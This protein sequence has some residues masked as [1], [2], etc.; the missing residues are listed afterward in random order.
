MQE[1]INL[2][3]PAIRAN[4]YPSYARMRLEGPV[5]QV[6]PGGY[7]AVSRAADIELVLKNPQ[8]FSSSGFGP[9]LQPAWLLNN[10]VGDSMLVKDGPAHTRLR[11]LVSS[12]FTPRA[13]ARLEPRIHATCAEVADHLAVVRE[14]DF[15]DELCAQLPG[16]VIADILGLDRKLLSKFRP[17]INHLASIS[18]IYPGDE[19]ANAIR[20]TIREMEG[21]FAEVITARRSAPSDD[22]VSNLIAAKIDDNSLTDRE[23]TAFLF[24]LLTAGFDTTAYF[25]AHAMLD[26]DQRPAVFT[27]LREDPRQIPAYVEELLRKDP[28]VHNIFR[29]TAVD[30]ELAGVPLPRGSMVMVVLASGNRDAARFAEPDRFDQARD[31]QAGLAF[32]HGGH[33]CLG[34]A[35]ARLEARLMLT[36]LAARFV[37][38]EKLPGEIPWNVA[39]HVRGPLTLP[40]RAIPAPPSP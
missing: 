28:P 14:G 22:I 25:F 30:T 18:P 32:G 40:F 21:H 1:P 26:F 7:W 13:L 16:L 27:Q 3:D 37:R 38:F 29:I 23:I 35:L 34:V 2:F 6:Q 20:A 10:P 31:S 12:V 39:L 36:E 17:W 15:I 19:I 8:I 4:P 24:L 33:Y 9:I 11:A 5:Q